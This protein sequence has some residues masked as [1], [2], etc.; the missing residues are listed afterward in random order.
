[1]KKSFEPTDKRKVRWGG[2]EQGRRK[3]KKR[4]RHKLLDNTQSVM[5]ILYVYLLLESL[6]C[7]KRFCQIILVFNITFRLS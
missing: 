1:M 6:D 3:G 4:R 5:E 2:R 7:N